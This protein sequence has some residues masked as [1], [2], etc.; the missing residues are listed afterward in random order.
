MSEPFI[1]FS[2]PRCGTH[3][4]RTALC[5]H[6]DVYCA[7]ELLNIYM[8]VP[9]RHGCGTLADI[10]QYTTQKYPR[11]CNGYCLH[12]DQFHYPERRTIPVST[13]E[14]GAVPSNTKIIRLNRRDEIS[15]LVSECRSRKA[16]SWVVY[17]Q[18][19][20]NNTDL[21]FHLSFSDMIY[22]YHL[23]QKAQEV[24]EE[25]LKRFDNILHVWYEDLLAD[26]DG[27]TKL[28]FDFLGVPRQKVWP[29]TIKTG[30]SL[31]EMISNYD[32]LKERCCGTVL[33]EYFE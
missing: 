30:V 28:M 16:N 7:T 2:R 13:K 4:V 27:G 33:E 3:M 25:Y 14:W 17:N 19:D 20:R 21:P 12:D 15:R 29:A 10:V 31:R 5:Q 26:W 18:E 1:L 32:E 6:P 24:T 23:H 11:K 22:W 8:M 9:Q